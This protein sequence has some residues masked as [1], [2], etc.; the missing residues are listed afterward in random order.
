MKRSLTILEGPAKGRTEPL[1]KSLMII[2][3][4][5]HADFQLG[6]DPFVSKRHLEVRAEAEAVFVE[7]LSPEGTALNGKPLAGAVSL[8]PGDVLTIGHTR[9]RY[10]ESEAAV[11]EAD[12]QTATGAPDSSA[13]ATAPAP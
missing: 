6:D 9:L 11:A 2:G 8:N 5:R 7:N 13:T 4:S 10:E 3:R 12:P 1:D